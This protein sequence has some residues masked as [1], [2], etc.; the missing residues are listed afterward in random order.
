MPLAQ[1]AEPW[2]KM[3][4][5]QLETEVRSEVMVTCFNLIGTLISVI[6]VGVDKRT[7]NCIAEKFSSQFPNLT[8]P[9]IRFIQDSAGYVQGN[10][11]VT[12]TH[13]NVTE[14]NSVLHKHI[15]TSLIFNVMPSGVR[16]V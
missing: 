3:E 2:P 1:L 6:N 11:K 14:Y 7:L 16:T 9:F 8:T 13:T 15:C 12:L 4:L 5:V 10:A